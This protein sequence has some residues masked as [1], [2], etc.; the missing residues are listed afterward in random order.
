MM[1]EEDPKNLEVLVTALLLGAD[2]WFPEDTVVWT[3]DLPHWPSSITQAPYLSHSPNAIMIHNYGELSMGYTA[4]EELT[5]IDLS[6]E[7]S[8]TTVLQKQTELKKR[9]TGLEI[10]PKNSQG[11]KT[12]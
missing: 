1:K 6:R 5:G 3:G 2:V 12:P 10:L 7:W 9:G 8:M 11:E 4:P